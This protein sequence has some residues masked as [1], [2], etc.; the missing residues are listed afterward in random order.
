MASDE[1]EGGW[2]HNLVAEEDRSALSER[3]IGLVTRFARHSG[4]IN[5][6]SRLGEPITRE[7]A[8]RARAYLSGLGFPHVTIAKIEDFEA[9]AIAAET[10]DRDAPAFEAEE[11]MRADLTLAAYERLDQDLLNAALLEVQGFVGAAS[12]AAIEDIGA[13]HGVD[14]DALLHAAAGAAVQATHLAAL[15][16]GAGVDDHPFIDK[17]QLFELGRWPVA[18]IGSTLH[19]F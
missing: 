13:I 17:F 19:L 18:I 9:A 15:V 8:R 2:S 4:E 3:A 16:L 11:A 5:W 1:F 14:D 12:L 10:L 6:F 7:D